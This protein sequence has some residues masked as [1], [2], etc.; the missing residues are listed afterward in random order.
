MQEFYTIR[1]KYKLLDF[2]VPRVMGILNL[3]SDSFYSGSRIMDLGS[4]Q[5]RALQMVGEGADILDVGAMSSRP[6]AKISDAKEE[7]ETIAAAVKAIR[8]VCPDI[9]ISVDTI[10]SLV[11][12]K[13]INQGAD[14]IN[15]ISAGSYDERLPEIAAEYEIPYVLM[16]MKGTPETMQKMTSYDD[17]VLEIMSFFKNKI[18]L[19]QEAGIRDIILDPGIGFAKNAENNFRLIHQLR[20]FEILQCPLLIGISRK[21]F[22]YKSLN[23]VPE[24]ALNG[25]TALHM[26][27]LLGGANI[28][29]VHDVREAVET[30]TLFNMLKNR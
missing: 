3:T 27:S 28:L 2:S 14:I 18:R 11:A 7:A 24:G 20:T 15:D 13:A 8:K 29:R 17:V 22:I 12:E 16:H 5:K 1:S 26:A 9:W 21:S 30:V 25:T 10:H 19:L 4:L 23:T 6:G